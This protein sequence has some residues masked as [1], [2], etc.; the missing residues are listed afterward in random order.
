MADNGGGKNRK[1]GRNAKR[2]SAVRYRMGNQCAKNKA[3]VA[4]MP[5]DMKVPR[6]TARALRRMGM[7]AP[8]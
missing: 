1:Y 2:P 5:K 6:G 4:A 3:T 8:A 7:Q